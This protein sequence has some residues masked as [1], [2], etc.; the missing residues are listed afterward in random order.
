MDTLFNI[1]VTLLSLAIS[2]M[3]SGTA[4]SA[5][6]EPHASVVTATVVRVIDGDTIMVTQNGQEERVRYIGIDTPELDGDECYAAEATNLN[7]SLVFGHEVTLERDVS[8]RDQYGRLLR[9]VFVGDE[10]VN[11]QLVRDGAAKVIKIQPDTARFDELKAVEQTAR[12]QKLGLWA[13]CY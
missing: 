4:P 11:E 9:Y 3:G 5:Q 10:L 7:S 12:S 1:L 6:P 2:Y 13:A 8:D